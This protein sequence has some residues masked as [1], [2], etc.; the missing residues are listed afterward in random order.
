MHAC[1]LLTDLCRAGDVD[2]VIG[3]SNSLMGMKQ[4]T[5]H[6]RRLGIPIVRDVVEWLGP[7]SYLGGR[8]NLLYWDSQYAFRRLL[9]KSD[10]IIGISSFLVE[11]FTRL[12]LPCVRMPA[13]I[14]PEAAPPALPRPAHTDRPFTL[15]YLGNMVER[16][17]PM[18]MIDAVRQV[19]AAG[20]DLIFHV[21]GAADRIPSGRRAQAVV[22]AD[23]LLRE[24]VRFHGRVSDEEVK[25]HL[26]GSD[27]LIFT[28]R[29]GRAARA[30]FPTR[31]P[32]YLV[33]GNPV[34]TSAVSDIGEYLVDGQEAIIVAPD[35]SA[36]LAD[37]IL[38]LL[39]L[40]DRGQSIGAAGRRKCAECFHYATR[41][42]EVAAFLEQCARRSVRCSASESLPGGAT[43]RALSPGLR[44][45]L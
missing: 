2:V 10:G 44:P 14:D 37:G 7:D 27:A 29:S 22:A 8:A 16:D 24:R 18:L 23:P 34:L 21:V 11:H 9:P 32:E 12:G 39:A 6:C 26:W 20:H 45:P 36:A 28:R 38:R 1:D 42:R 17:G 35:R 4:V 3:Y 13:I 40:P 31:L 33:T 30:A 43:N 15:T 41:A 25:R 5:A 19:A